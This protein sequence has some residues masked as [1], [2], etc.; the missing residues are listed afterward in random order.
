MSPED[1]EAITRSIANLWTFNMLVI[2]NLLYAMRA[3]G[4]SPA[5][6]EA[7]LQ[8]MDAHVDMLEGHDDQDHATSLLAGV[9]QMLSNEPS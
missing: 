6:I 3:E 8:G 4:F 1:R 7:L 2:A 5:R 9:R